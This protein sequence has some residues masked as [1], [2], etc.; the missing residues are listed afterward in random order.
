MKT[1]ALLVTDPDFSDLICNA[2]MPFLRK[3]TFF[4]IHVIDFSLLTPLY[5]MEGERRELI[6]DN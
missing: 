1:L 2:E 4:A 5:I 6:I 3:M